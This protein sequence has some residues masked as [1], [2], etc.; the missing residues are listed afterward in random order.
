MQASTKSALSSA[1]GSAAASAISTGT[2]GDTAREGRDAGGGG[3]LV[4]VEYEVLGLRVGRK[5]S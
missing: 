4:P 2:P 1:I 5:P 3:P